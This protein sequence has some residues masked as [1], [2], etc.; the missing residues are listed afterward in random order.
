MQEAPQ[1]KVSSADLRGF[2]GE[3]RD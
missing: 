3:G 2:R 1:L